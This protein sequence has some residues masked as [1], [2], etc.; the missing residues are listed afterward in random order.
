MQGG[1]PFALADGR[2]KV[3]RKSLVEILGGKGIDSISRQWN[4]TPAAQEFA[5]LPPG[6]YEAEVTEGLLFTGRTRNTP[7][8]KLTFRVTDG[9]YVGRLIWHEI[10]LT[11]A[12]LPLAKRD[13][14]KLG[15]SSPD[16][17]ERPLPPGIVCK[18]RVVVHRDD[19][20][21]ERNKVKRFEVLR[22]DVPEADAFAPTDDREPGDAAEAGEA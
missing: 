22:I 21:T 5:A 17:L 9:D 10:W 11:E 6:D 16:A 19:D 8:Y 14:G 18:V 20:G 7:G 13:L 3:N 2:T 15:I 1:A 12:A 4:V